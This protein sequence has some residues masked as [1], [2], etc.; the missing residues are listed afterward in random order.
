MDAKEKLIQGKISQSDKSEG[1]HKKIIFQTGEKVFLKKEGTNKLDM[2]NDG[3]YEVIQ[4]LGS[5]ILINKLNKVELVHKNRTIQ[6][7][8]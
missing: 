5:N 7:R 8:E 1:N 4:E 6:F 3:R 2:I